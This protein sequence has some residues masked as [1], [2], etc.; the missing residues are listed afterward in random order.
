MADLE[1]QEIWGQQAGSLYDF[2]SPLSLAG[3]NDLASFLLPHVKDLL[4]WHNIIKVLLNLEMHFIY[5]ESL[6]P[7]NKTDNN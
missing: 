4:I 5:E 7:S 1:K 3:P 2:L 6:S